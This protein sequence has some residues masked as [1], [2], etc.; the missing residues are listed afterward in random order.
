M[1]T[2]SLKLVSVAA[3]CGLASCAE[4]EQPSAD[5]P[6]QGDEITDDMLPLPAGR[7]G[8]SAN[9]VGNGPIA[10]GVV[11]TDG[12]KIGGTANWSSTFNAAL[13]RY[14]ISITGESYHFTS[15][16]TVVTPVADIRFC[17]TSSVGGDLLVLCYNTAGTLTTSRFGFVVSKP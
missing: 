10:Y 16:A 5:R 15:Y 9:L 3:L 8:I 2:T 13:S 4:L 7:P 11:N 6:A 1:M 14:E 17:R 12:S